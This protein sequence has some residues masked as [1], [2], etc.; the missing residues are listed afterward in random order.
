MFIT[1]QWNASRTV[2]ETNQLPIRKAKER[3]RDMR[4]KGLIVK[5]T[6]LR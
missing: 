3:G 5:S 6:F 1:R 2:E 4:K